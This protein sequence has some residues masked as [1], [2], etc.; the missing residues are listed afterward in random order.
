MTNEILNL[1]AS[2]KIEEAATLFDQVVNSSPRLHEVFQQRGRLNDL[3]RIFNLGMID[4]G[5]YLNEKN[6]IRWSMMELV[7]ELEEIQATD[8][9]IARDIDKLSSKSVMIIQ[10]HSGSGDN[11]GGDYIAG[12]KFS[13]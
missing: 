11:I 8:K 6:K 7:R 12:D 10:K 2:D 3:N 5:Q 4:P 13:K 9:E 1:I